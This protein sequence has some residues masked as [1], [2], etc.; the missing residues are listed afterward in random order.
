[1]NGI[2]WLASY[3]HSGGSKLNT[4]LRNLIQDDDKP[5]DVRDLNGCEVASDRSWLD[6]VLGF[7][8]VDLD[9][10]EVERLRPEVYRWALREE[11]VSYHEIHD[12][13]TFTRSGEPLVTGDATLGA[14][15]IL[16]NPFDVAVALA[17]HN[18]CSID[19]AITCMGSCDHVFGI[20]LPTQV[21]QKLLSWSEHILS[22]VDAPNLKCHVIRYEDML[23]HPA[24]I[25]TEA[26]RFLRLPDDPERLSKAIRFTDFEGPVRLSHASSVYKASAGTECLSMRQKSVHWRKQLTTNQIARIIDHHGSVMRRFGY[27]DSRNRPIDHDS[28]SGTNECRAP[29]DPKLA[30]APKDD[31]RIET[32][33]FVLKP[34]KTTDVT[35]EY[36]LWWNDEAI[37]AGLNAPARGW[38]RFKAENHVRGHDNRRS[39]HLGVF[40][41][42]GPIVGFATL[43]LH[44]EGQ[45]AELTLV[46]GAKPYWGKRVP[47]EVLPRIFDCFFSDFPTRKIKALIVAHNRSSIATVKRTGFEKEGVLRSEWRNTSGEPVDVHVYSILKRDWLQKQ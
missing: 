10:E 2:H 31:L 45:V 8:T 11:G 4:F 25:L 27:L 41:K 26:A 5:V 32:P 22:W 20:S 7:D 37:Q 29:G 28:A 35:E 23:L 19:D 33:R 40:R 34:L 38:D 42:G 3:P 15:Y 17:K 1:M 47:D 30:L 46:I 43:V 39:F 36:V 16:R 6:D 24:A 21:Q 18:H 13:Y 9:P 12:A 44:Q 14:I